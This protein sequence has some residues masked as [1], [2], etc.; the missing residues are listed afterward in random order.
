MISF[1]NFSCNFNEDIFRLVFSLVAFVAFI[2][3]VATSDSVAS[4]GVGTRVVILYK[5]LIE[6]NM[7]LKLLRTFSLTLNKNHKLF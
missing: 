1:K 5:F 7:L 6:N 3:F 2:G 4:S